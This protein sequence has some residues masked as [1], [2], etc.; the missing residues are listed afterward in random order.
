MMHS[1]SPVKR[2]DKFWFRSIKG[3]LIKVVA[4]LVYDNCM[5]VEITSKN[6]TKFGYYPGDDLRIQPNYPWVTRRK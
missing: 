6:K 5:Q 2:G 3:G 4:T 1:G